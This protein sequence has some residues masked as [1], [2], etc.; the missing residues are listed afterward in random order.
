[1]MGKS[2]TG[3]ADE[4]ALFM[5]VVKLAGKCGLVKLGTIA[6]DGTKLRAKA[7]KHKATKLQT[8]DA[9]AKYRRRQPSSSRP[10]PG[11]SMCSGFGSS[12]C[13]AWT[14]RDASSSSFAQ[15]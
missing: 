11:S 4:A 10:T 5:Q 15:H 3:H 6:V 14:R 1:M 13:E 12:A 7:S 9:Q 2:L 8:A